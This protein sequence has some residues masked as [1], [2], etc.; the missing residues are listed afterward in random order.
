MS[1]NDTRGVGLFPEEVESD[2]LVFRKLCP[3]NVDVFEL[4]ELMVSTGARQLMSQ[5][6]KHLAD[7]PTYEHETVKDTAEFLET[8]TR[9]FEEGENAWYALESKDDGAFVGVVLLI[10]DWGRRAGAPGPLISESH[11][12]RGYGL[13]AASR[14][15]ELIF[16]HLRLPMA[17]AWHR[18][19][20]ADRSMAVGRDKFIEYSPLDWDVHGPLKNILVDEEVGEPMTIHYY[21]LDREEFDPDLYRELDP[22]SYRDEMQEVFEEQVGDRDVGDLSDAEVAEIQQKELEAIKSIQSEELDD[23][24]VE[25]LSAAEREELMEKELEAIKDVHDEEEFGEE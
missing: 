16:E 9:Q 20:G 8:V 12:G 11:W 4:Y 23:V 15:L 14:M 1:A 21:T 2:R 19:S 7:M 18:E 17:Y 13:E 22:T 3:E 25:E 10:T 24:D 5:A 6:P